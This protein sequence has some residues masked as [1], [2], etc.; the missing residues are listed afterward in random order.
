MSGCIEHPPS[1]G[2][3]VRCGFVGTWETCPGLFIPLPPLTLSTLSLF[4]LCLPFKVGV[5]QLPIPGPLFLLLCALL[6]RHPGDPPLP[7]SHWLSIA[8]CSSGLSKTQPQAS[9]CLPTVSLWRS[10]GNLEFTQGQS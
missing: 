2:C 8:V 10:Q 7:V 3:S 6:T 9:H 4:L 5:P 1:P